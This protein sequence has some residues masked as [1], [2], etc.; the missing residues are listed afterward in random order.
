MIDD[1]KDVLAYL[2]ISFRVFLI[3]LFFHFLCLFMLVVL[4]FLIFLF[5]HRLFTQPAV[6]VFLFVAVLLAH[7]LIKNRVLSR[8]QWALITG[9]AHYLADTEHLVPASFHWGKSGPGVS[10]VEIRSK[11]GR[12]RNDFRNTGIGVVSRKLLWT[13]TS[14]R[15][16]VSHNWVPDHQWAKR[17]RKI[18][19]R[20]FFLKALL[21][22]LLLIPF[23]GVSIL[24]TVG[25]R[26]ELKLIVFLLGVSFVYFL[27][28][29]II[30]PV[31]YLLVEKK[32]FPLIPQFSQG[33]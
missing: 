26:P 7:H 11:L 12:T 32:V 15:H 33:T 5:Y 9:F 20:F 31:F 3:Q 16:T 10:L 25:V 19:C 23:A 21:F 4:L 13:V 27:N 6:V 1:L 14:L 18:T 29:A 28:A 24:F 30:E 22:L 8:Q 2:G 17:V